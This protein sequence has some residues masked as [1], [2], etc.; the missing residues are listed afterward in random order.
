MNYSKITGIFTWGAVIVIL[1]YDAW[2]WFN[3]GTV[4]TISWQFWESAA[5]DCLANPPKD[6]QPLLPWALGFLNGHLVWQMRKNNKKSEK[7]E[8]PGG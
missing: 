4:A 2:A 1:I 3:G 5:G 6:A 8:K 7:E